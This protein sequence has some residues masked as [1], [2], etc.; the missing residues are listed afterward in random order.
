MGKGLIHYLSEADAQVTIADVNEERLDWIVEEYGVDVVQP[1]AI[2]RIDCDVF[3]PCAL[4][5]V[6]NDETIP[7]LTS[8]I[9]CGAANNQLE[10]PSKHGQTLRAEEIL[11]VPDFLANSGQTINNTDVLRK[12]GYRH[13]RVRSMIDQIYDRMITI[14]KR[15]ES[16]NR[17]T[18]EVAHEI[19]RDRIA[20][21]RGIR[22]P[23]SNI[24]TPQW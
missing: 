10:T 15:A 6:L 1:D 2:Y 23:V 13:E 17:P 21:I 22:P 4:G 3:A 20:A 18:H 14:G 8:D 9:V 24:R 11:Y 12:G 16:E 5:G 7:K 19:A